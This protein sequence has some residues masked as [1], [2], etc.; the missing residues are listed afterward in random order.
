M[1]LGMFSLLQKLLAWCFPERADPTKLSKVGE[2]D[3]L[4]PH[5]QAKEMSG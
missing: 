4:H 3:V 5:R 1:P 2:Y